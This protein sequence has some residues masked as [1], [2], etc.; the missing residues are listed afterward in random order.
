VPWSVFRALSDHVDEELVDDA[1]FG[2]SRADGSPDLGAVLR[3]VARR[4]WRIPRLVRLGRDTS[5]ATTTAAR[6]AID[7]VRRE[8]S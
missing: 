5:A 1:V 4:P 3:Y 6:A 8:L 2:L 7:A